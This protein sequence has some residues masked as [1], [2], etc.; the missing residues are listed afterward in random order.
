MINHHII[1]LFKIHT[2]FYY[3]FYKGNWKK[4]HEDSDFSNK[5]FL[6]FL[7]I[8]IVLKFFFCCCSLPKSALGLSIIQDYPWVYRL[9]DLTNPAKKF[10]IEANAKQLF[11]T[12]IVIMHKECN[13]VAVEGGPKQQRKFRR[14][15]L[16]RIKWNEDKHKKS[17]KDDGKTGGKLSLLKL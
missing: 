11:M 10:K 13:V 15:M 8:Y 12:G 14:L 2:T 1:S 17:A 3:A 6:T 5:I 16:Q 4:Q 9:R 7:R